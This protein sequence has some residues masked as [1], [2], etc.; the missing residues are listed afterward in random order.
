MAEIIRINGLRELQAALKAAEDA[1]PK[2]LRLALNEAAQVVIDY[3]RPQVP[4]ESGAARR[5]MKV[6]STQREARIS[7][8]GRTAPY[9]PWLDF[10]GQGRIK[11]RPAHRLF[12]RE[13]RYIYPTLRKRHEQIIA[14]MADALAGVV[15]DAGLEVT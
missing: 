15:R 8:G 4:T 13:G 6:R 7:A 10:G 2:M 14:T 5:S 1:T 3:A 11:G 12:I 9:Y